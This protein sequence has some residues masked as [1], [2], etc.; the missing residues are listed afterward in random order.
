MN[1]ISFKNK[2]SNANIYFQNH[3]ILKYIYEYDD[4]YSTVGVTHSSNL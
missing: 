2:F 4:I 3:A 1:L